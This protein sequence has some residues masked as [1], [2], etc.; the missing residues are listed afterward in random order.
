MK[1]YEILSIQLNNFV[2]FG[3]SQKEDLVAH[4]ACPNSDNCEYDGI[5]SDYCTSCKIKWLEEDW[6]DE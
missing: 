6:A 4:I 3:D 5:N 1:R 2:F